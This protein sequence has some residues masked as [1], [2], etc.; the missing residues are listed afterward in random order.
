MTRDELSPA[1]KRLLDLLW[2]S[3]KERCLMQGCLYLTD[4]HRCSYCGAEL[5]GP[6]PVYGESPIGLI[7]SVARA[8]K[9]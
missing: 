3:H 5:H 1:G 2:Q 4:K 8:V 9:P 6:R 7:N